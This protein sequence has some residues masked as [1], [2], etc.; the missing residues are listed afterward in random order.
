M[1]DRATQGDVIEFK[2]PWKVNPVK[3]CLCTSDEFT[4]GIHPPG[5]VMISCAAPVGRAFI[6]KKAG[7]RVQVEL[8]SGIVTFEIISIEP[9]P[10][11]AQAA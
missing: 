6:G 8:P 7:D 11:A 1:A 9:K 4:K 10:S 5:C 2:D 3:G